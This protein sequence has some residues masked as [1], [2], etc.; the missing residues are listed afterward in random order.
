MNALDYPYYTYEQIIEGLV[1]EGPAETEGLYAFEFGEPY[2]FFG[3]AK[4]KD[5]NYT[6]V[7]SSKETTFTKAGCS[8]AEEFFT[9]A[10]SL[11]TQSNITQNQPPHLC[12]A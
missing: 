6:E 11:T 3:V 7:W 2:T 1:A 4:D 5:G 12:S 9:T 8:P 10:A